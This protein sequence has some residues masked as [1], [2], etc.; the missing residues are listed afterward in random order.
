MSHH[1]RVRIVAAGERLTPVDT[2]DG[3]AEVYNRYGQIVFY[4]T[5]IDYE[6]GR[7]STEGECATPLPD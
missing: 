5:C 2:E 3:V 4:E 7:R 1:V 6:N